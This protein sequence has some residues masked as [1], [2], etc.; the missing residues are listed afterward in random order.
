MRWNTPVL[1][2]QG[3]T[4]V[5]RVDHPLKDASGQPLQHLTRVVVPGERDIDAVMVTVDPHHLS[6]PF[7]VRRLFLPPPAQ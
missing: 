6:Q 5:Y 7:Q 3:D 2:I 4:H 1:L